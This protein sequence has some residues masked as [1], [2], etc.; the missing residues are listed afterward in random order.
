M[1]WMELYYAIQVIVPTIVIGG[2][3]IWAFILHLKGY[4]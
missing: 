1:S 3:F 2:L 4:R